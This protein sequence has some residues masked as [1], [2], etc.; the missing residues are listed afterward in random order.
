M[1]V[2]V[3]PGKYVLAVSG[4]VDSMALLHLLAQQSLELRSQ[5]SEKKSEIRDLSSEISLV[6]AHFNHGIRPD[7]AL[8]EELVKS[9]A[10]R[11]GL[12][13][14]VGYGKLGSGASEDRARQARYAFLNKIKQRHR[15]KAIITAHHQ[16]DLIETAF[17]NLLRGSGRRGLSA[18]ANSEVVR[19]LLGTPKA[20]IIRYA[21]QHKLQ[22]REDFTNSDEKYLRNYLRKSLAALSEVDR[23]KLLISLDKITQTNKKLDKEIATLSHYVKQDETINRGKFIGL[24][25]SITSELVVH[26]LREAGVLSYDQ[27]TVT[28]LNTAIKT[29]QADTVHDMPARLRLEVSKKTAHFTTTD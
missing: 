3:L 17:L 20:E 22:W 9:V 29:A 5:S 23:Q 18:I 14:V 15:A 13:L 16:D 24:P 25:E 11:L 27:K 8:D 19:P 7:S 1:R 6:V 21:Q 28:R 10:K 12:E 4:G 26:W 2:K